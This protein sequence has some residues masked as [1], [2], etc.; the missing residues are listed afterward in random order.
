MHRD[1]RKALPRGGKIL[2]KKPVFPSTKKMRVSQP[3]HQFRHTNLVRDMKVLHVQN[4]LNIIDLTWGRKGMKS[5][6][7]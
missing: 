1:K 7:L 5:S 6:T 2:Y 3:S 4:Y